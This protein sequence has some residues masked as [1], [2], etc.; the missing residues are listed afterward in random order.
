MS[1]LTESQ[2]LCLSKIRRLRHR[3][4]LGEITTEEMH[5]GMIR[6][7]NNA[8]LDLDEMRAAEDHILSQET[9][10]K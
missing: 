8:G 2:K 3:F 7:C 4:R 1:E 6:E 9:P 10:P 5:A